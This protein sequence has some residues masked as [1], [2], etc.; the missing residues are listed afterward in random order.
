MHPLLYAKKKY[1]N[2]YSIKFNDTTIAFFRLLTYKEYLS[3]KNLINAYSFLEL[4]LQQD[5]LKQCL[6]Q[7]ISPIVLYKA[8]RL[9]KADMQYNYVNFTTAMEFIEAGSVDTL[10]RI[11]LRHSG[12]DNL[13][14]FLRDVDTNRMLAE[15][16][17]IER[18]LSVVSLTFKIPL[19]DLYNM[20]YPELLN[21]INQT[22]FA[23]LG[24][25]PEVPFKLAEN[26]VAKPKLDPL[27]QAL[28]SIQD[29]TNKAGK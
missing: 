4:E 3:Y 24:R 15:I 14:D 7:Y 1:G 6:L 11:I 29:K 26:K 18:I 17:Y 20:Q 21:L 10:V 2:I 27:Q 9:T 12:Q 13:D 25:I 16:N 23:I 22:E 8:G 5:I 28:L 19:N